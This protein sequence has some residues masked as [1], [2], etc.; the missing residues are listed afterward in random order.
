MCV[1]SMYLVLIVHTEGGRRERGLQRQKSWT[2][3]SHWPSPHSWLGVL[4]MY[5]VDSTVDGIGSPKEETHDPGHHPTRTKEGISCRC[6]PRPWTRV[7]LSRKVPTVEGLWE[8]TVL[9]R[10]QKSYLLSRR[11]LVDVFSWS[12]NHLYISTNRFVQNYSYWVHTC[13]SLPKLRLRGYY[14]NVSIYSVNFIINQ[15]VLI[16]FIFVV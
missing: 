14:W 6:R 7:R 3:R 10:S 11:F 1:K 15:G 8:T 16:Q 5:E 4:R 13:S 2:P 9:C 12:S